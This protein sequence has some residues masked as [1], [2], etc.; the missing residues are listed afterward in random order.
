MTLWGWWGYHN[1]TK[2]N[3]SILLREIYI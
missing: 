1:S 3:A 2:E